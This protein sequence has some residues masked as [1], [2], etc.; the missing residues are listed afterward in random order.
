MKPFLPF[1]APAMALL[2]LSGCATKPAPSFDYSH[3]KASDP[4]SILVLPPVNNTPEIRAPYSMLSQV[5]LPLAE[6][7]YYVLPVSL[8]DETLKENGITQAQDAH[9]LPSAKLREIFGADAALFI[10]MTRYGT[11]YKV[12]DSQATVSAEARLVDLKTDN[13]LWTGKATASTAEQQNRNQ[14]SAAVMLVSA[15]VKQIVGTITDQSHPL[16]GL[17]SQ[18]LLRAG[19]RDGLLYGPRSPRYKQEDEAKPR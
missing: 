1:L 6:S 17:T 10:T 9:D 15:I 12:I 13:V 5:T 8:V 2:V 3:Y 18:R 14:G 11:V 7:G 4:K 19:R 16:A